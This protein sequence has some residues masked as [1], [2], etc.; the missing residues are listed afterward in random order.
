MRTVTKKH[1]SVVRGLAKF[2]KV[3][4]AQAEHLSNG[5]A[6]P[7]PQIIL[8]GAPARL[9]AFRSVLEAAQRGI[10]ET[11][12]NLTWHGA[13]HFVVSIEG[14]EVDG[15][16][17]ES[18]RVAA[19]E[20]TRELIEKYE[21]SVFDEYV[22]FHSSLAASLEVL[23]GMG[24]AALTPFALIAIVLLNIFDLYPWQ[25]VVAYVLVGLWAV[26]AFIHLGI[27][28]WRRNAWY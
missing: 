28:F 6:L 5:N 8:S 16:D 7:D 25:S 27:Y 14:L 19:G 1:L 10:R 4:V 22:C 18:A 2:A 24:A 20:A 23:T 3:T 17:P 21:S 12:V 15:I 13:Q 26:V 9:S 11:E